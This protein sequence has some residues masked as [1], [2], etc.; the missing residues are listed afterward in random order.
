[1]IREMSD[2]NRL[3][4][5]SGHNRALVKESQVV[6]IKAS[7]SFWYGRTALMVE[8]YIPMHC[9][10]HSRDV[11]DLIGGFDEELDL[12]EDWD[13]LLRLSSVCDFHHID[14]PTCEYRFRL[15]GTNSLTAQRR[16]SLAAI[17]RI[18]ERHPTEEPEIIR[19]RNERLEVF[20]RQ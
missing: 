16:K 13:F 10:I 7:S 17:R 1:L 12:L 6:A 11:I 3:F 2:D 9:W 8:N 19:L 14:I 15:D 5:H 18:Y 20:Q 4:V